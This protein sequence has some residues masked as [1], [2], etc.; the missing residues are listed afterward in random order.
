[1]LSS[2]EEVKLNAIYLW[3]LTHSPSRRWFFGLISS[4]PS[5]IG[6]TNAGYD[7]IRTLAVNASILDAPEEGK[8]GGRRASEKTE[9]M[10]FRGTLG[11]QREHSSAEAALEKESAETVY[12]E[13]PGDCAERPGQVE[14]AEEMYR[15][16]IGLR[17]TVLGKEHPSNRK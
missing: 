13:R 3:L 14:Q 16:A 2:R 8:K 7:T 5:F 1:L 11:R 10:F 17:E 4:L 9:E 12:Y 15:Q 6:N